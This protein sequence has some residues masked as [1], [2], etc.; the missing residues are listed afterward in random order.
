VE[1]R[2]S[3]FSKAEYPETMQGDKQNEESSGHYL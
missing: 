2:I 3:H 1:V